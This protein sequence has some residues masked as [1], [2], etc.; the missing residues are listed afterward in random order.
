ME[1]IGRRFGLE[2]RAEHRFFPPRK[3]RFD[4]ALPAARVAL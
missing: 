2:W 4:F 3:W 1:R